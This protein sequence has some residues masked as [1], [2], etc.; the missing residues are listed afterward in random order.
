MPFADTWKQLLS[1]WG[2][3]RFP[4]HGISL[5]L[6]GGS[7]LGA[8]HI[9]VLKAL[10]EHQLTVKA[11]SGTSI[12]ALI[13]ALYA[14]GKNPQE[15]EQVITELRWLDVTSFTL[16]KY[17]I[18]SHED[19]GEEITRLLGDVTFDESELPLFLMATDIANGGKK[20]LSQGN[21]AEA[22]MASSCIPGVFVPVEIDGHLL[23]DGGLVENVPVSPLRGAGADF[24]VG[25]DL[26]AGRQYQ[27]PKDIIDVFANAI[28]IAI[29]NATRLQTSDAD[30]LIAPELSSYNRH[31]TSNVAKLIDEGYKSA[32]ALLNELQ[33]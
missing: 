3:T 29:D 2:K 5:A 9:G 11:V 15:I 30:L 24:I 4:K 28:D 13:A 1:I 14:F 23:V 16:S 20:V 27:R 31:D 32:N 22:V 26:N 25:V 33:K 10:E 7:V 12:G 21:V 19:L 18:L 6:G 8:A 17:G